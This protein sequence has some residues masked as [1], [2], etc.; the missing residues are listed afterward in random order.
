MPASRAYEEAG[1][2]AR[3]NAAE[4][5]A[6]RLLRNAKVAARLAE[7]QRQAAERAIVTIE[8]IA[9]QLDEDRQLARELGQAGAA[10][11]ATMSKAKIYGLV[12]D[13]HEI[14]QTRKPL[15]EP[16]EVR[17]MTLSEWET[18][19]RPK[20]VDTQSTDSEAP[21]ASEKA[22]PTEEVSIVDALRQ[23]KA[24]RRGKSTGFRPR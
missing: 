15:R 5:N 8:S 2:D 6:S 22:E 4:A 17:S 24:T 19:F 18:K 9:R 23:A 21:A 7:L 16:S 13:R 3:N 12:T 11:S 20:L 14:D 10:V 1:Y